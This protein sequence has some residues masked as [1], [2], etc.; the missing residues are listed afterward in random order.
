MGE[1]YQEIS[2]SES[3]F[4]LVL[5]AD[6]FIYIGALAKIFNFIHK[7]LKPQGIFAFSI[8]NLED[9]LIHSS[10]SLSDKVKPSVEIDEY[11]ID[12]PVYLDG[13]WFHI[14]D[15]SIIYYL[16]LCFILSSLD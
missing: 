6:T 4:D 9:D 3:K 13:K 16:E 2:L 10:S 11:F 14:L 8:E 7:I 12:D 5:A 1:L 15:T